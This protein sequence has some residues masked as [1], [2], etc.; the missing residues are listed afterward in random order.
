MNKPNLIAEL[1]Q[2]LYFFSPMFSNIGCNNK[3]ESNLCTKYG[4]RTSDEQKVSKKD[5]KL[6]INEKELF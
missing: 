5:S 1:L 2:K 3:P 6:W 4:N